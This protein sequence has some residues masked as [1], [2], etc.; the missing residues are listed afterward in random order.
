MTLCKLLLPRLKGVCR[1][2]K[3]AQGWWQQQRV[4]SQNK[5]Q[6]PKQS[7]RIHSIMLH[8][9][10]L[11]CAPPPSPTVYLCATCANT[12]GA[13]TSLKLYHRSCLIAQP[14]GSVYLGCIWIKVVRTAG[15]CSQPMAVSVDWR[16]KGQPSAALELV[17][18]MARE[19]GI[20]QT[21]HVQASR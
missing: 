16:L 3:W 2:P 11:T 7:S 5:C 14:N 20:P 17:C 10:P 9:T 1:S 4:P 12:A 8:I 21:Q 18:Q 19:D 6:Q 13:Q 15:N